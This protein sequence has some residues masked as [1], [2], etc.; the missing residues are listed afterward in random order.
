MA[1]VV[2][3]DKIINIIDLEFKEIKNSDEKFNKINFKVCEEQMYLKDKDKSD[4]ILYLVIKFSQSSLSFGKAVAPISINV[5]GLPFEVELTHDF[6]NRFVSKYDKLPVDDIIQIYLTPMVVS[7]FNDM[8]AKQRSLFLITGTIL[9]GDKTITLGELTYHYEEDGVEKTEKIEVL[10]YSEI[11]EKSI[12]PQPYPNTNG[13]T[14]SHAN[15]STFAFTI[16]TYPD[17]N[18]KLIQDIM[19]EK[20]SNEL[21]LNKRYDLSGVFT[22][23]NINM[24]RW[25]F[26]V[27][28][29]DFHYKLGEI[30]SINITFSL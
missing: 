25:S 8:Y 19:E 26:I 14:K 9:I 28:N 2:D 11:F 21:L 13:K 10:G 7:N 3:Y 12:A 29:S 27:R 24:P 17:G 20:F 15:F 30:P 18:K 1:I 5:I 16:A 22:N 23:S 4:D 6:L